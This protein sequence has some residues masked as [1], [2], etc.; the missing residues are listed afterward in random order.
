MSSAR[1]SNIDGS[2][3]K[4]ELTSFFESKGLSLASRQHM[5][6]I[7]TAEGQKT[8]VVSFVDESTLKKALSLPSAERVL[9]DRVIDI[10]DGFDGY[11]V[12]SEGTRVDILALHGLNGH[13]FRS[14]ESH[15]ASFMWLRDCLPEQMP[16]VRIL[17][18][19]YNANVYSDVSTGRM[20]TFSETF[21]ERLRYMRES[22]PDRPLII[23][24]HSMG[25][26]IVK[27]AL[28]IAHT[29]ADGRFD[30]IINSVTGIVF[31]GTP[32]QGGNGVDAA[33]FVANFVRAFNIDVRVDLIKSL[34]PKSMVL[35]DLTDDFRQLVSS[36]G[37]EIATL[38]ET[39]KTKIGVFSSKVWIVEERSA[40][41]GVVR[42]R[43]AA[44]DATH[45]NLCKFRSSTDSSLISTL[46]VL[47]EFCKDV[48]PIISA[49]HQTTQPPPPEDLKYVALSNPD[50]L[51][52]SR[53]YP[54][55]ILGQYTYWALSYVDNRYA[56]AILAYD[57]NGRIVG[58]WSKQGA[59]YVHRIEFDESNRQVSFVGQ[60]NLSVV[61]HLSE[62]KVTSS[63]R[64]YG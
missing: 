56:M 50:E 62:L 45:T 31:L 17:T 35:F 32:H 48:V 49:R 64:L 2:T 25:G 19:G 51:D 59:R 15:D 63:T 24:A 26:L 39:K 20:R 18:Y 58:R 42:E 47:K 1:V 54:V 10:D 33:K 3:T 8:S 37:I 23:I 5:P 61:F 41:L 27:Q 38:Y 29:R 53:E 52:S 6:F 57:S 28:L 9:N 13:A 43:K 22:D 34:D 30:S 4:D 46:Q 21:L 44:I 12:L 14:W 40:I 11:T 36:K 16:G 60:G 55:F 7:C